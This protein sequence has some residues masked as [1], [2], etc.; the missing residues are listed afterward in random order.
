MTG[1]KH[2]EKKEKTE[3]KRRQEDGQRHTQEVESLT[4]G[5]ALSLNG[6]LRWMSAREDDEL[7]DFSASL[8]QQVFTPASGSIVFIGKHRVSVILSDT[9]RPGNLL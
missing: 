3:S 4:G 8:S 5:R 6:F 7:V 2:R 1:H 9:N